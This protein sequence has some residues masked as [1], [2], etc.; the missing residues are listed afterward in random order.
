MGEHDPRMIAPEAH[1]MAKRG[2]LRWIGVADGRGFQ[3]ELGLDQAVGGSRT[4]MKGPGRHRQD[5]TTE[6]SCA[7]CQRF[8][9]EG[10]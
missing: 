4:D 9:G 7:N 8:E 1:C 2:G 6:N 5:E 10:L 3:L